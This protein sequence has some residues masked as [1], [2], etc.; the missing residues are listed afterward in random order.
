MTS[1]ALP[2]D[3]ALALVRDGV[4]ELEG[5]LVDASNTTLRGI[6]TLDGVR[7][8]CVYKPV[9]GER[10]LWDF[11]DGTLAGRE[12]AAYQVSVAG[13][14]NVVPPTV[15]R[16]GPLGVGACQLWIDEPPGAEPMLGFVPARELPTGWLSVAPARD[17]TGQPF[18]L[19]HADDARLARLVLFD[20]V[21]NN[22]DRK[23]GH[24]LSDGEGRLYGVDHGVCFHVE[25]KL[26]T[27]LWGWSGKPLPAEAPP[28]LT[29]LRSAL[30]GPLRAVLAP[31][32]S[33]AEVAALA[34]RVDRLL[35]T[36]CFPEPV[37]DWPA[38]PWP[39]I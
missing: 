21:A 32:I 29:R 14:W 30:R 20:A 4:L 23:G 36:G 25:D 35:A 24:V 22:A 11:P 9:R 8:R 34:R 13:G 26:R 6:V 37:H 38:L 2:D 7:A 27:V 31:H 18:A 15:L 33:P 1:G 17:E 3:L 5:R 39:P 16:D 12:V 28:L 19:A 10:P